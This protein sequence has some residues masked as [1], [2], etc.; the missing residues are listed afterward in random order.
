[1][2]D[3]LSGWVKNQEVLFV[4]RNIYLYASIQDNNVRVE[5]ILFTASQHILPEY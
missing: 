5:Y 2:Q 4:L 1:M 3:L